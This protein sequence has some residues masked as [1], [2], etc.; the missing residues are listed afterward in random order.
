MKVL[1]CFGNKNKN[2]DQYC[3]ELGH[4]CG[5]YLTFLQVYSQQILHFQ[6][7][8]SLRI[9]H[10][11]L[12]P[13]NPK[14]PRLV[15]QFWATWDGACQR[16]LQL[17]CNFPLRSCVADEIETSVW[18][19]GLGYIISSDVETVLMSLEL[20]FVFMC[21]DQTL[22]ECCTWK[23]WSCPLGKLL[24]ETMPLYISD[25]WPQSQCGVH[26]HVPRRVPARRGL[27]HVLPQ[28]PLPGGHLC[29]PR[30]KGPSLCN[31]L[32]SH[33]YPRLR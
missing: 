27:I 12:I 21:K 4:I 31:H 14:E 22:M 29:G 16:F 8:L 11:V 20:Q 9:Q 10:F 5:L 26:V 7:C 6:R 2:Q 13:L 28:R 15:S 18:V 3:C 25:T 23:W 17:D 30:W 1:C 32:L 24:D 19:Q 33:L